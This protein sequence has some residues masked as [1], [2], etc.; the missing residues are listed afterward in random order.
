MNLHYVKPV[1]SM[2]VL[3]RWHEYICIHCDEMILPNKPTKTSPL[4]ISPR[5][6]HLELK[7]FPF[8]DCPPA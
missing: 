7:T 3:A 4:P 6:I 5:V 1:G 2:N 8:P